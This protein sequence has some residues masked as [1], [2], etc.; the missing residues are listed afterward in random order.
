MSPLKTF[1]SA[2]DKLWKNFVLVENKGFAGKMSFF[3]PVISTAVCFSPRF[4][5]RM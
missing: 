1:P 4:Q 2:G 5:R 3:S